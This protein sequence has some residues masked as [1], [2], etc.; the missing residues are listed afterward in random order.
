MKP[1]HGRLYFA[2][3][4]IS[5]PYSLLRLYLPAYAIE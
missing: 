5:L 1:N 2:M 4:G 3:A